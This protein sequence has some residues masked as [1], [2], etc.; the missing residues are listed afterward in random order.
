[1]TVS[2]VAYRYS[3]WYY[4]LA[5][6]RYYGQGCGKFEQGIQVPLSNDGYEHTYG[7]GFN[8]YKKPQFFLNMNHICSGPL[9]LSNPHLITFD[10]LP[11]LDV[12]S[13]D[14]ALVDF[15]GT[16]MDLSSFHHNK[17]KPYC[18]DVNGYFGEETESE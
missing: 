11:S 5:K 12:Y 15:L 17:R 8:P 14:D 1:M 18:S 13:S 6:H 9:K 2:D 4:F 16:Y 7:L 10:Q 3:P